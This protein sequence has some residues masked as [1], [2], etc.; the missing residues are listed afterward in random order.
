MAVADLPTGKGQVALKEL[1]QSP[2]W[3]AQLPLVLAKGWVFSWREFSFGLSVMLHMPSL[4]PAINTECASVYLSPQQ[5]DVN[6]LFFSVLGISLTTKEKY[7]FLLNGK[8]CQLTVTTHNH[9]HNKC[10]LFSFELDMKIYFWTEIKSQVRFLIATK[11]KLCVSLSLTSL[12]RFCFKLG[13]VETVFW[14]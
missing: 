7:S 2:T 6:V 12:L 5:L 4:Q 3:V 13:S 9:I 14:K 1:L 11:Q 8:C 10:V